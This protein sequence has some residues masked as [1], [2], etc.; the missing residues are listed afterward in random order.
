MRTHFTSFTSRALALFLFISLIACGGGSTK[1]SDPRFEVDD[2]LEPEVPTLR[3]IDDSDERPVAV[4]A[5]DRG[6]RVDFVEDEVI[7]AIED[8]D[9]LPGII[10]RLNGTVL[11]QIDPVLRGAPADT[12]LFVLLRIDPSGADPEELRELILGS[13]GENARHHR[14]SS[15][16]ALDSLT[17]MARE[18]VGEGTELGAN[19]LFTYDGLSERETAEAAI[20]SGGGYS[21]NAFE[22]PYMDLGSAQDIGAAEAARMVHDAGRVPADGNKVELLIMD[23]GMTL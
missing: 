9:A 19:F 5:D 14:V 2:S 12:P 23:G 3:F 7:L 17:A 6:R 4:I 22:L 16:R 13:E 10:E 1:T 20:G 18:S 21:P 11:R 8:R 15:Q